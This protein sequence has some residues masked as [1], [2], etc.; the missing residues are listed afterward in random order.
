MCRRAGEAVGRQ[1]RDHRLGDVRLVQVEVAAG[2]HPAG[3]RPRRLQRP[4]V[5]PVGDD[6]RVVR[7][8]QRQDRHAG[9][10]GR[11]LVGLHGLQ[12]GAD[13]GQRRSHQVRPVQQ[14]GGDAADV[15]QVFQQLGVGAPVPVRRLAGEAGRLPGRHDEVPRRQSRPLHRPGQLVAEHAAEAVPDD[16]V[17]QGRPLGEGTGEAVDERPNPPQRRLGGAQASAGQL[18]DQELDPG[19]DDP[20]PG[21]ERRGPA[22]GVRQRHQPRP[23]G[24]RPG[25]GAGRSCA[26]AHL[27][28]PGVHRRPHASNGWWA[29]RWASTRFWCGRRRC[30]GRCSSECRKGSGGSGRP[31]SADATASTSVG[32]YH[33]E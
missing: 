1:L 32:W 27:Q 17:R 31:A 19:G 8:A 3:E 25:C 18:G 15:H 30:P 16:H 14:V 33:A 5:Q 11:P 9:A 28:Q 21:P 7:R 2:E 4:Q 29:S 26:A 13:R 6:D 10:G 12:V 24:V 22:A 23:R 20:R